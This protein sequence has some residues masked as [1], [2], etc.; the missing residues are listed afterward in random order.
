MMTEQ[1]FAQAVLL[2]GPL[3]AQQKELLKVLCQAVS[4]SLAGRMKDGAVNDCRT[5]FVTAASLCALAAFREAGNDTVQEF[6]AG[7]LTVKPGG[8][9]GSAQC[10][11]Q[12]AEEIIRPF[13]KDRFSFVGV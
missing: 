10:L 8:Q 3:T 2:A 1:I 11:R 13:L 7:D 4:G 12:Q 5:E 9:G 6:R